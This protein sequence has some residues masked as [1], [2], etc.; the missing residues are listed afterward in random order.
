MKERPHSSFYMVVVGELKSG[1]SNKR[2]EF[3][4]EEKGQLGGYLCKLKE[5]SQRV[6]TVGFLTDGRIIQYFRFQDK[7]EETP[8][9]FLKLNESYF[10]GLLNLSYEELGFEYENY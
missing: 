4:D 2:L 6:F 10:L 1:R 8:V 9:E 5:I 3:T 7:L